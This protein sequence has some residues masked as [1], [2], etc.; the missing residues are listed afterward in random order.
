MSANAAVNRLGAQ[1]TQLLRLEP[2]ARVL[3]KESRREGAHS[4][5][6]GLRCPHAYGSLNRGCAHA[7]LQGGC[8]PLHALSLRRRSELMLQL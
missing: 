7:P 1:P 4:G 2:P 3:L 5:I 8:G 6:I